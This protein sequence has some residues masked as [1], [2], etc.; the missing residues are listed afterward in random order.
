MLP[1]ENRLGMRARPTGQPMMLQ[2]WSDL[3]FLHWEVPREKVQSLLPKGLEVDSFEDKTYVGLVPFTMFGIRHPN[4]PPLPGISR[5][6]ETNVR[7]YVVDRRG[8]PGVYFLSLEAANLLA[9]W[10]A[11][12]LFGLPYYWSEM[13]LERGESMAYRSVRKGE[14]YRTEIQVSLPVEHSVAK[15]GSLE[16]FLLERYALFTV[17]RGKLK[18]GRV[19]HE[20]Y[21]FA[22][23]Q[24]TFFKDELLSAHGFDELGSPQYVHYSPGVQVEVFGLTGLAE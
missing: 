16:F 10:G 18:I 24:A 22:P 7:V 15:Q 3:T 1:D 2:T 11:R 5:F 4:M 12:A 6:H 14:K 13:A 17:F 9:V 21:S 20:P 19:Y 8:R 23:S